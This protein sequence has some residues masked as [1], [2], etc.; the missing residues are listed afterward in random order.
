M[1]TSLFLGGDVGA[2]IGRPRTVREAGPYGADG[3]GRA[4]GDRPY[5]VLLR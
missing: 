5:G 3:I 2:A 4:I 1:G